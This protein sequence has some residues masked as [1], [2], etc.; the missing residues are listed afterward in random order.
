MGRETNGPLL[1]ICN[2]T[3]AHTGQKYPFVRD[4]SAVINR[5]DRIAITGKSGTGKTS[6]MRAILHLIQP[7][8]G[9]VLARATGIQRFIQNHPG[10][11]AYM[12][13]HPH[14]IAGTLLQNLTL[15]DTASEPER[16]AKLID[17]CQ[18]SDLILDLP[19]GLETD[20]SERPLS[21]GQKQRIGLARAL[22]TNPILLALDEP[23]SAL[24][25]NTR[26]LVDAFIESLSPEVTVVT[27]TH[28]KKNELTA[29]YI[30]DI[31]DGVVTTL[32]NRSATKGKSK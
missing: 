26:R 10:K 32:D 8:G 21:G 15:E 29:D 11:I 24:D 23:T 4:F 6:L 13:Q 20:L 17:G 19:N 7:T 9:E 5:G 27:V 14:I 31:S 16:L 12:P 25:S 3:A 28:A 18:L 22:Y 2:L 1:S 30:W